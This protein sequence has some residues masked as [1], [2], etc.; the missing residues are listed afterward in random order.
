MQNMY[1]H[2]QQ[3]IQNGGTNITD[4]FNLKDKQRLEHNI[5]TCRKDLTEAIYTGILTLILLFLLIHY[6][7]K[8]HGFIL[9]TGKIQLL[10]L[11]F[12]LCTLQ[13]ILKSIWFTEKQL[14]EFIYL[15]KRLIL[16][17]TYYYSL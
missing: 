2:C 5:W 16:S 14:Y 9:R 1:N 15:W 11:C 12:V 6:V 10:F 3:S 13:V 7:K 4:I 8:S 17:I